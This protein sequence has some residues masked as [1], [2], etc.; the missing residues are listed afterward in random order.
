MGE[1]IHANDARE[2]A[3]DVEAERLARVYAEA[4]LG[5]AG[6]MAEQTALVEALEALRRDVLEPNPKVKELFGSEL[7]SEDEKLAL[8]DRV[9][10]GRVTPLLLNVLKVLARHHRLG[11]VEDVI[12]AMKKMWEKRAGRERVQLVTANPLGPE[13]ENELL[14]SLAKALGADP[15]VTASV[16]PDLIAGFIIR[17][18]DR[19]F[20]GS[21]RTRLESM[22]KSMVARATEAIQ[23]NPQRFFAAQA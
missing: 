4:A 8:L 23:T 18:G 2:A 22:R 12:V 1:F 14:A 7:V 10:G 9:F 13:L 17:V 6:G 15:I 20:D 5:A 19:V 11:M 16:D 21:M 3:F